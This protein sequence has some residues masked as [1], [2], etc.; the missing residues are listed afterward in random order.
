MLSAPLS[1][2]SERPLRVVI[3][4]AGPAGC[5]AAQA[6]LRSGRSVMV[7]ILERLPT[8]H[9]LVRYGVAPDHPTVKSK[10]YTFDAILKD[11][12]VR[13]LGNVG[14]RRGYHARRG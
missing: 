12:R 1:S 7:D 14:F 11:A 4:G 5:Y 2:L 8:P 6:L 13:Y 10:A 9:G 3:V